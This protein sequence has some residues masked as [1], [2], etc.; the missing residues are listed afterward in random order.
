MSRL[1]TDE[2]RETIEYIRRESPGNASGVQRA[3][4]RKIAQLRRFPESASADRDAPAPPEGVSRVAHASGFAIRYAFPV[5]R[6]GR[7]VV[8]IV[9][10]QRA[11]RLRPEDIEYKLRFLQEL[12]EIYQRE[13]HEV[14]A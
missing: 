10:I 4:R 2:L 7:A 14:A 5:Q 12:A 3:I 13:R 9:A 8:Y 1:A 6:G 11:E